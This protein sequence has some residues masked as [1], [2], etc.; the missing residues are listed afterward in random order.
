MEK[1]SGYTALLDASVLF[2]VFTSNLLLW[3]AA[4]LLYRVKWSADIHRE[5]VERRLTRYPGSSR[6]ALERK[7]DRMDQ[8][9]EEALVTGYESLIPTLTLRD[10]DDRHV[11]AAAIKC[12][13]DVIV[14]NNPDDFDQLPPGLIVQEADEFIA[15]QIGV[16]VGSAK[17]VAQAIIGHKRSLT[18]SRPTWQKY[19]AE[20]KRK[21]PVSYAEMNKPEFRSLIALSVREH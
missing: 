16:T 5:W 12:S 6:E 10:V 15:A 4:R 19:F 18:K 20:L 8:E 14:T 2:P 3:L 21:L 13:A 1:P 11:L 17:E 9:F 7:R